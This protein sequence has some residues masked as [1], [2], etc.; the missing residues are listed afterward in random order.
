[1]LRWATT[2]ANCKPRPCSH[3]T[4]HILCFTYGTS[5]KECW[6]GW[7]ST[8]QTGW[9]PGYGNGCIHSGTIAVSGDLPTNWYNYTLAT[10][11]TIIDEDTSSSNPATNTTKATES[12]CPKGWTLPNITQ[13]RTLTNGSAGSI[14]YIIAF[15]SIHGGYYYNGTLNYEDTYGRWWSSEARNGSTRNFLEYNTILQYHTTVARYTGVYI[16]CIQAP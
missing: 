4:R 13:M 15:N 11:G 7:N 16:R 1:M 9:G 6:G 10:A 14:E 5:G 8:T 12:I 3:P 2:G